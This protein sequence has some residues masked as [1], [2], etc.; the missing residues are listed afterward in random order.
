MSYLYEGAVDPGNDDVGVA[1]AEGGVGRRI[2]VRLQQDQ[3]IEEE[4]RN[5]QQ[6][7]QRHDD[8]DLH[9]KHVVMHVQCPASRVLIMVKST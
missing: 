1:E 4:A 7:Q 5:V 8:A 2:F 6:R 9:L 3:A